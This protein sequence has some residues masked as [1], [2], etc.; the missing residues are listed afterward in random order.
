MGLIGSATTGGI[1]SRLSLRMKWDW[2]VLDPLF[3]PDIDP[4]FREKLS[5]LSLSLE[6][7]S[8]SSTLA[9]FWL[10]FLIRQSPTG[11]GSF[12]AGRLA[13]VL[14]PFMAKPSLVT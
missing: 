14:S 5:K 3:S 9:P 6:I 12:Q 8:K 10:L 13:F 2:Y 1:T 4:L 11:H 7:S